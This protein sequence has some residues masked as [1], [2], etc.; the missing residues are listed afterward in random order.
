MRDQDR[1]YL[2]KAIELSRNCKPSS[3]AYSVGAVL[4]CADGRS[5][6]GYTHESNSKNH[7]EEEAII[8]AKA[9]SAEL[10]GATMYCTMEPCSTRSSKPK[11]CTELI[12]EN[13]FVRVLFIIKEPDCFVQCNGYQMLIDAGIEVEVCSEL[14]NEVNAINSHILD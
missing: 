1:V 5:Y 11:S 14:S 9:D 7:A 3:G 4:V 13:G 8:K 12:L 10:R 2:I 6:G